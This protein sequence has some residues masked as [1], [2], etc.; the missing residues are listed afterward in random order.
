[1]GL[2]IQHFYLVICSSDFY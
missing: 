1:M 2:Y